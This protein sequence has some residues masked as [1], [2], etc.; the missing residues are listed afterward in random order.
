LTSLIKEISSSRFRVGQFDFTRGGDLSPEFLVVFLVYMVADSNRRGVRHLLAD[1]WAEAEELGLEL[2]RAT[3]VSAAAICG[4]RQRLDADVFRDLLY[5]LADSHGEGI[6]AQGPTTWRGRRV[7]AV[8]GQKVN[9]R[10]SDDLHRHFGTP[11]NAHSP[12][13]LYSVLVDV[14]ARMPVDFELSGHRTSERDHLARMLDS[15]AVGDLLILDRGYP[16][17]AI[18]QDLDARGIDFVIRVPASH[19][20]GVVDDFRESGKCD[21]T[22]TVTPPDDA[23]EEWRDLELRL[24]RIVGSNEPAFYLTSLRKDQASRTDIAGLYKQRWQ[25]EEYFKAFTGEYVGQRQ[26]R[27]TMPSGIRQEFGALTLLYALSR[28]VAG[29]ANEQIEVEGAFVSQKAAVLAMGTLLMK[30]T[31]A[32]TATAALQFIERSMRRLLQTLD[33]PRPGRS[34]PRRSLKPT[35]KWGPSGRNGR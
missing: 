27:S 26:F 20:F 8:D 23:P 18:L 34:Y 31:L 9:L 17:H 4:A 12:L 2:P 14:C 33:Q 28:I 25:V 7:Y 1:L 16:S 29:K 30:V 19:S 15:L 13:A 5:A 10:R 6:A 3:P 24:V 22:V 11:E 21:D 32:P 35:P